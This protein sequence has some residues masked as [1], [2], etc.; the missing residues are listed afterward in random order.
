ML[1]LLTIGVLCLFVKAKRTIVAKQRW[2]DLDAIQRQRAVRNE[3]AFRVFGRLVGAIGLV[4]G[5]FTVV[6]PGLGIM[7]A[8]VALRVIKPIRAEMRQACEFRS[9]NARDQPPYS[10]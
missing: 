4:I 3:C 6:S 9:T 1:D 5:A 2:R 10:W 8:L 7:W